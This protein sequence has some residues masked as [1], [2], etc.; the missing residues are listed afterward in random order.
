MTE[1]LAVDATVRAGEFLLTADIALDVGSGP[2]IALSG[3][4]GSG[5]SLTLALLA[6][7]LR[8]DS[9]SVRLLGRTVADAD[10]GLHVRTQERGVGMVFQEALLLPH[11]TVTDNV[12]LA[13]RAGSRTE[14]RVRAA[15][16]L[17]RVGAACLAT[18]SPR[19]LSGGE[20]QRV[21]LARA[22][23][24]DP[25][26]LLLDEPLS[27]LDATTRVRLREL[28]R[29]VVTERALPTVLVSHDADE[30]RALADTVV[31]Y[32]PGRT[33]GVQPVSSP[34]VSPDRGPGAAWRRA[35]WP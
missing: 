8:P 2:V 17:E 35:P 25:G 16:E 30:V 29:E 22:L 21:A 23:A 27:A 18:A 11:R 32:E 12:A 3:P 5:K 19:T 15:A 28:L 34:T 20:R 9:G 31:L 14:R 1:L 13:V 6:G 24:G 7:L 4:S 26:L 10:I 33:L